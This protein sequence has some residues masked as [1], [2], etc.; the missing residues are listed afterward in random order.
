METQWPTC[1]KLVQEWQNFAT[2][3]KG[4]TIGKNEEVAKI[5]DVSNSQFTLR[6]TPENF[7]AGK[8][9]S[10]IS[11][12]RQKTSDKWVLQT[13][14]GY[15]IKLDSKPFQSMIPKP[16]HFND[17]ENKQI[18]HKLQRFTKSNI[19]ERVFDTQDE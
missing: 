5:N 10:H 6:N 12:W 8:R 15:S 9:A 11:D 1:D 16:L 3:I 2:C 18:K 19:I 14:R 4:A 17:I 7:I 13:V